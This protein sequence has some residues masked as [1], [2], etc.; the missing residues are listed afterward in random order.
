MFGVN[1][2]EIRSEPVTGTSI[3]LVTVRYT[4]DKRIPLFSVYQKFSGKKE[5]TGTMARSFSGI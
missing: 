3:L 5:N 1:R 2:S 4:F